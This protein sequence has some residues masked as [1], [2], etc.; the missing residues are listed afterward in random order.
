M[1]LTPINLR[2]NH[3]ISMAAPRIKMRKWL[4]VV[5]AHCKRCRTQRLNTAAPICQRKRSRV[6]NR[7]TQPPPGIRPRA[8]INA[9]VPET[10]RCLRATTHAY[11]ARASFQFR[12]R[13][14][15]PDMRA[16]KSMR[17]TKPPVGFYAQPVS[18]HLCQHVKYHC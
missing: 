16:T 9:S 7:S 17:P 11:G 5:D 12:R 10:R 14:T 2:G 1:D 15:T 8:R 6:R 3:E 18:Y 4:D 13:A